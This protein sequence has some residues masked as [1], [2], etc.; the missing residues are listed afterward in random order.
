MG[1]VILGII[2]IGGG[3]FLFYG[4][5]V[6]LGAPVWKM[7]ALFLVVFGV[8]MLLSPLLNSSSSKPTTHSSVYSDHGQTGTTDLQKKREDW[9]KRANDAYDKGGYWRDY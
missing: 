7:I 4:G 6:S 5:R 1:L 3:I 2:M 8:C 9:N